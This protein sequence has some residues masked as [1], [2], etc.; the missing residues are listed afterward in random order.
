[1]GLNCCFWPTH[2]ISEPVKIIKKN[3]IICGVHKIIENLLDANM[4]F[5]IKAVAIRIG[6]LIVIF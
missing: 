1:M 5:A 4:L 6:V 3:E 2:L